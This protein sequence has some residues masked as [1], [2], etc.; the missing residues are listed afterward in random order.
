LFR[1]FLNQIYVAVRTAGKSRT[2][3]GSAFGAEHN[4]NHI[5]HAIPS[6]SGWQAV[7]DKWSPERHAQDVDY[8]YDAF[9][10]RHTDG[11]VSALHIGNYSGLAFHLDSVQKKAIRPAQSRRT[12]KTMGVDFPARSAFGIHRLVSCVDDVASCLDITFSDA[13]FRLVVCHGRPNI[14]VARTVRGFLYQTEGLA[15]AMIQR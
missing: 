5:P 7:T 14:Q 2:V 1:N 8:R 12:S 13:A 4:Q 10:N 3:F 6:V 15:S 9:S 11:A